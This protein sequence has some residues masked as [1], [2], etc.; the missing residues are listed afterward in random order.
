MLGFLFRLVLLGLLVESLL[1]P[2]FFLFLFLSLGFFLFLLS[3][4]QLFPH[5]A[6]LLLLFLPHLGQ[7][8]NNL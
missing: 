3:Q 7:V 8:V 4:H 5:A 2:G 1:L 6:G